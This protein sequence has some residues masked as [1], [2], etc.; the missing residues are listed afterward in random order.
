MA[1][2]NGAAETRV[3]MKRLREFPQDSWKV[4]RALDDG[5]YESA[6]KAVTT[7][8]PEDVTEVV[9]ES[10]LR[11]RGGAGFPTLLPLGP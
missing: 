2:K 4:E 8:S 9:K 5:A 7:M 1:D 10:G 11:G 3:V 6:R